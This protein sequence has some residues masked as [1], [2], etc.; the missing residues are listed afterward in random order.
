MTHV[1]LLAVIGFVGGLFGS[2][3]GLG[4]GI[5][6]IPA[7]VLFLDVPVHNAI[8]ASLVGVV[9][10]STAAAAAYLR[11]DL[12]NL[13]LGMILETFT[14]IGAVVG[15][16]VGTYLSKGVLSMVF[17]V[18][19]L[20]VAVYMALRQRV[21]RPPVVETSEAG[22]LGDTYSD[23]AGHEMVTYRVRRLPAGLAASLVA[24]VVSGLL[25]VGGGFLK[26]PVMVVAMT[27]PVRAAVA[28][29]SFM[30]GITACVGGLVYLAKGLVD[31]I[32]TVPVV[33]G[34]MAGA[35]LGSRIAMRIKSSVL[36][37]VLAVVLFA[38][39][40]QMVLAAVGITV[41]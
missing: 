1:I 39:A 37:V 6:M 30:I 16:M 28:T 4:G 15:G 25:G 34:V 14:A 29:S 10:T 12:T 2:M 22:R 32:V 35:L 5:F 21:I 8:A 27:V 20:I 3:V 26:V 38:L 9:A 33:L 41:R 13:R 17:G 23:R 24:G 7:L 40:A 18:V 31:P 36:T 19:M 11:D